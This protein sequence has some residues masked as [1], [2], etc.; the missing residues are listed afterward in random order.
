M[1][2]LRGENVSLKRIFIRVSKAPSM[3]FSCLQVRPTG[4]RA[5]QAVCRSCR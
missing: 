2:M 4:L 3:R 5:S 1:L